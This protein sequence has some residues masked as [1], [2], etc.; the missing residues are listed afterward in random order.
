MHG[1]ELTPVCIEGG[2]VEFDQPRPA[3]QPRQPRKVGRAFLPALQV[4]GGIY[5]GSIVGSQ[6]SC[7]DAKLGGQAMR[8]CSDISFTDLDGGAELDIGLVDNIS[9]PDT[10]R[11]PFRIT[12]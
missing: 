1:G 8:V 11:G 9:F 2:S 4:A 5:L 6:T 7:T 12:I 3:E 10:H